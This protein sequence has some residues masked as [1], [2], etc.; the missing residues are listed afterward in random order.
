MEGDAVATF[1]AVP[2]S[3]SDDL[4]ES[5][6][7]DYVWLA[8]LGFEESQW[9]TDFPRRASAAARNARAGASRNSTNWPR[10][11]WPRALPDRLPPTARY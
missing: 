6:T 9:H 8:E 7:K 1:R 2:R 4:L 10:A 3:A 5:V 11:P